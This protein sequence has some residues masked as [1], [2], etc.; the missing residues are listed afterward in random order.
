MNKHAVMR[1]ARE[2]CIR[3]YHAHRNEFHLTPQEEAADS[4]L[5]LENR[6]RYARQSR[7]TEAGSPG[8]LPQRPALRLFVFDENDNDR[9]PELPDGWRAPN[10]PVEF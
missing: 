5:A 8:R 7:D 4:I 9:E 6:D 2:G 3:Q 1:L 10:T